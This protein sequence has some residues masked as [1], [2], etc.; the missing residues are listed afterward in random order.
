MWIG[1][2]A[3]SSTFLG[4]SKVPSVN[5]VRESRG[6]AL[7]PVRGRAGAK[8]P[9]LAPWVHRGSRGG[10]GGI[11]RLKEQCELGCSAL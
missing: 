5:T 6:L 11:R 2:A 3:V 9:C 1:F 8:Y 7:T 10:K 4:A